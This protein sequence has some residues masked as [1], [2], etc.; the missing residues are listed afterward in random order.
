MKRRKKLQRK[1]QKEREREI[2]EYEENLVL[3][4][5]EDFKRRREERLPLERQWELNRN[6]LTGNQYCDI[7]RRGE[8]VTDDKTFYWQNRGVFNHIAPIIES[9]LSRFSRIN[10][11]ISVR[12][13]TDDDKDVSSAD[14]AEKLVLEVFKSA[15]VSSV[16]KKVT[17]WSET[18]GTG[19]YKVIWDNNGGN[20]IADLDGQAIYEGEVRVIAVSPFEIFPDSMTIENIKD[21]KSII[22]ARVMDVKDIFEKYGVAVDGEEINVFELMGEHKYFGK[23][24]QT[25][26]NSAIVIERY[27]RPSKE[28]PNGRMIT[29]A[30]N[31]LLQVNTLPYINGEKG[32][33]AFPFIKQECTSVSGNFFG[34]SIIERLIPIQRAYNAVKNRKH[35][36]LNRLCMGVMTVEDGS[37]DVDDLATDGLSPGKVLVYR[38]GAKAPEMMNDITMPSEFN[39]EE[40]K[41]INEFVIVSGVSDVSSSSEN[42][43][44]TS[45]SA[46]EILV[47]Q[48]N[49][50]LLIAAEIIRNCYIEIAK[51]TIRLYAQFMPELKAVKYKDAFNKTRIYYVDKNAVSSDD[52]FLENENELLY[53]DSQKKDVIL[54]LY[55]SGLLSDDDG[56]LR[57]A[58]KEK[59]L[60]LLGYKDL[61]YRKGLSRLQEEKAQNEN[62]VIRKKGMSIESV[63]DDQ[64]H[65][66]EHIRYILSEYATLSEEE[67]QKLYS[68]VEEHKKRINEKEKNLNGRT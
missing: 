5:L 59:V 36:F 35:E 41:L 66:D 12:P 3:E 11:T 58:T 21:Q 47:E 7:N 48:D 1:K 67:K 56:K 24:K 18:C 13:K 64:I 8:I 22:H 50:R 68:H 25:V 65:L 38:Q 45:G 2:R 19:F 6:F 39:E 33:R 34:T 49:S 17:A 27:E 14:V 62:E 46:L 40:N 20:K 37:V 52:V 15:D 61:D 9:R 63:D 23:T 28:F 51:Q 54:K 26:K 55:N 30:G 4:V 29:V 31:K 42:A 10:P 44:V 43:T 53:T 16:V 32:E 60:S 57:P